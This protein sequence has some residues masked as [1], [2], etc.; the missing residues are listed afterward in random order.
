MR[1]HL[2]PTFSIPGNA[3]PSD[4][5]LHSVRITFPK[6]IAELSRLNALI[7][8]ITRSR[9]ELNSYIFGCNSILSPIRRLPPEMLQEIFMH[10][11]PGSSTTSVT[12]REA[13]LL[14]GR[15]C[16]TWREISI[17]TPTLWSDIK[18]SLPKDSCQR[19]AEQTRDI[20]EQWI[21]RSGSTPLSISLASSAQISTSSQHA[22]ELILDLL[23]Q[24]SARWRILDIRLPSTSLVALESVCRNQVPLLERLRIMSAD[25]DPPNLA[26]VPFLDLLH[27]PKLVHYA[28]WMVSSQETCV[29]I[30]D[31][32]LTG[33]PGRHGLGIPAEAALRTLRLCP[34]LADCRLHI[35]HDNG[36]TPYEHLPARDAL[37]NPV[38][39]PRLRSLSLEEHQ[40]LSTE[41]FL[42]WMVLPA[43]ENLIDASP[44]PFN[45]TNHHHP[46]LR[47]LTLKSAPRARFTDLKHFFMR[48][49]GLEDLTIDFSQGNVCA[50]HLLRF[51]ALPISRPDEYP[52]PNLRNLVFYNLES[53]TDTQMQDKETVFDLLETRCQGS[54]LTAR[55]PLAMGGILA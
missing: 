26:P 14:L 18:I 20:V 25:S 44:G 22:I 37:R 36:F 8:D 45:F 23:V 31:L 35:C 39:L 34:N 48:H 38:Q 12:S 13:P 27:A 3:T 7:T 53:V 52:L 6:A 2:F 19:E 50:G 46:T 28:G 43:L 24:S 21:G 47:S 55:F 33:F 4:E 5:Q 42:S 15:V 40:T 32:D 30:T 10:C 11:L 16:K 29:Q 51:L 54:R 17:S 1:S 41:D 9:D 49:V